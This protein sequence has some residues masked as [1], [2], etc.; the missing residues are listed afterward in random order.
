VRRRAQQIAE[1]SEYMRPDGVA[2]V[3]GQVEPCHTFTGKHVEVVEPEVDQDFLELP[4]AVGG[5]ENF[6]LRQLCEHRTL[7]TL[8]I[9]LLG[10]AHLAARRIIRRTRGVGSTLLPFL[11]AAHHHGRQKIIL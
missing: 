10:R 11:L 5:A 2:L 3:L 9:H 7:G 8:S 6:L 1:A 4:F